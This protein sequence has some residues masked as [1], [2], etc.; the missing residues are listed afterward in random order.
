MVNRGVKD[1][2]DE[3]IRAGDAMLYG[4]KEI[5]CFIGC[6]KRTAKRYRDEEGLP[7]RNV[8]GRVMVL[9][10]TIKKWMERKI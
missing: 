1:M 2:A 7:V 6:D 9:V 3:R 5:S 4:W 10:S 8:G